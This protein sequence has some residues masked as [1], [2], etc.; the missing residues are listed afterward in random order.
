MA[1]P[2]LLP[3]V[4]RSLNGLLE[5]FLRYHRDLGMSWATVA[6]VLEKEIGWSPTGET[7][8]RWLARYD[9][10]AAA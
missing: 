4:D 5:P 6:R 9:E 1:R 2:D 8:R 3:Y 10:E 7:L